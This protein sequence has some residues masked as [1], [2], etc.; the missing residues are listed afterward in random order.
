MARPKYTQIYVTSEV[1][2]NSQSDYTFYA[3]IK[4]YG[5]VAYDPSVGFYVPESR[6]NPSMN[7]FPLY[8]RREVDRQVLERLLSS[9]TR[10]HEYDRDGNKRYENLRYHDIE[11][12][13]YLIQDFRRDL[14]GVQ[15]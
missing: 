1:Y 7:R 11:R 13:N 14:S 9:D 3:H 10:Y 8:V 2:V 5:K 6:Q 15:S 12:V 4:G